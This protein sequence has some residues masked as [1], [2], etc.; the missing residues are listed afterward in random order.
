MPAMQCDLLVIGA[1]PY[2]I[3]TAAY[4]KSRDLN[5][6]VCARFMEFWKRSMPD[7]MFLRSDERWHLDAGTAHVR[8]VRQ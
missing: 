1:G 4:A 8:G 5:V 6:V 7:G 2:G 3:A